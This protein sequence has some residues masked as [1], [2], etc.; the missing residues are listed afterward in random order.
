MIPH[1]RRAT[2]EEIV[3]AYR[4]H[5]SVWQA[6]KALGLCG[7][8]VWERLRS[9]DYPLGGRRWTSAEIEELRTL[10]STCPLAEIARRLGRTYAGLA[11]KLSELEIP[12][13]A[14]GRPLK[15]PRGAGYDKDSIAKHLKATES[16][17]G[18]MTQYCRANSIDIESLVRCFQKF[19]P[20]RWEEYTKSHSPLMVKECEYCHREFHPTMGKQRTCSRKCSSDSRRDRAY[21]GGNRRNT[22]GLTAGVCQLCGRDDVKGLSSHHVFGK[23]NDPENEVL[24][25]LCPGCHQLVGILASR[26]F[27]DANE[28]WEALINLVMLRRT[29]GRVNGYHTCV[30][31]EPMTDD[32]IAEDL[33][34]EEEAA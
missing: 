16:F 26:K 6:A 19:F 34:T 13:S 8:S 9:I 10:A 23:E 11:C 21:F 7:Q 32:E 24:I 27:V 15:V 30:E 5:G 3:D 22:I 12:M 20:E 25:A 14:P 17:S 33:A 1:N 31:I 4:T 29:A 2:I 18:T 28:G